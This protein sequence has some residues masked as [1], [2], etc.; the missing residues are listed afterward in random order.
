MLADEPTGNLDPNNKDRVLDILF[1]CISKT[2]AALLAV[3]RD[4][5]VVSRFDRVLDFKDFQFTPSASQAEGGV[6]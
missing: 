1:E 4:T 6:K 3:T 2:G 5:S